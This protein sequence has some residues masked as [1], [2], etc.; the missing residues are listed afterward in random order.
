[1]SYICSLFKLLHDEK[2]HDEKLHDEKLLEE[3]SH[4]V[5]I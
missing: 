1:V 5:V 4:L 2:L 3:T